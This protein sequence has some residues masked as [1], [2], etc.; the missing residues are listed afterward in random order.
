MEQDAGL[1]GDEIAVKLLQAI[2]EHGAT[3]GAPGGFIDIIATFNGL[4]SAMAT[5][6]AESGNYPTR[7]E[8]RRFSEE[9]AE[10][11]RSQVNEADARLAAGEPSIMNF[12]TVGPAAN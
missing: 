5:L 3:P 1:A 6:A 7:R 12:R 4:V 8:V 2:V 9:I 11:L 10:A